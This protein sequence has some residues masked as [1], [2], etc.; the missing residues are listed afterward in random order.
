VRKLAE[1]M[2]ET[3]YDAPGVGLAGIQIGEAV[4]IVTIPVGPDHLGIVIGDRQAALL[5]GAGL[6]R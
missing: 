4:R 6:F 5:V 2:L 1:D 3:M